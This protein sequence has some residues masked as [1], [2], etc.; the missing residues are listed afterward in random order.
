MKTESMK[1]TKAYEQS[2]SLAE[3]LKLKGVL[4]S[5]DEIVNDAESRKVSYISFIIQFFLPKYPAGP[6]V[7]LNVTW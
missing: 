3:T 1:P 4:R 5:L 7:A 6:S 2:L